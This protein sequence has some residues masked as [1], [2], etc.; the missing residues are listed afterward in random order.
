MRITSA[1]VTANVGIQSEEDEK[2]T[3]E[4]SVGVTVCTLEA[5]V[6]TDEK[7]DVLPEQFNVRARRTID[8]GISTEEKESYDARV[9]TEI[10]TCTASTNTVDDRAPTRDTGVGTYFLTSNAASMTGPELISIQIPTSNA[11]TNTEEKHGRDVQ[12]GTDRTRFGSIGVSTEQVFSRHVDTMTDTNTVK[13]IAINTVELVK[14]TRDKI[15]GTSIHMANKE[16]ETRVETRSTYASTPHV[17]RLDVETNTDTQ[18]EIFTRSISIGTSIT[19]SSVGINTIPEE[20]VKRRS[21]SPI[22]SNSDNEDEKKSTAKKRVRFA[23]SDS[24]NE[25]FSESPKR[26]FHFH[27]TSKIASNKTNSKWKIDDY[28]ITSSLESQAISPGKYD[29]TQHQT[30]SPTRLDNRLSSP[31]I[32][33]STQPPLEIDTRFSSS[34]PRYSTNYPTI[35]RQTDVHTTSPTKISIII[36]EDVINITP[37]CNTSPTKQLKTPTKTPELRRDS[38]PTMLRTEVLY[39]SPRTPDHEWSSDFTLSRRRKTASNSGK[40]NRDFVWYLKN[41]PIIFDTPSSKNN[42]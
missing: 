4:V 6:N 8:I 37:T 22:E 7:E 9:G 25:H 10:R 5:S 16:V 29:L 41:K 21:P 11:S 30:N 39:K 24:D 33:Q 27:I 42:R 17:R 14:S 12:V 1:V 35:S 34:I 20:F 13:S 32:I 2:D 19:T 40:D 3:R 28:E 26:G 38:S 31:V 23:T 18:E 15:V 36:G